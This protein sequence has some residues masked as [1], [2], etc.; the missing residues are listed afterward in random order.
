VDAT[1]DLLTAQARL[2]RALGEPLEK[3]PTVK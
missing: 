3:N 2:T 1:Y